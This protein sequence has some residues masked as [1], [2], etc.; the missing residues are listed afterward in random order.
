VES[1]SCRVGP[2]GVADVIKLASALERLAQKIARTSRDKRDRLAAYLEQIAGT[3]RAA[4]DDLV[5]GGDARDACS[6][7][8]KFVD[9]IPPTV[10]KALGAEETEELRQRLHEALGGRFVFAESRR[11]ADLQGLD[12]AAGTFTALA[13]YLRATD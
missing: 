4:R 8:H 6:Q 11:E 9:K 13:A 12:E 7:L 3:L 1:G 5:A 2:V 10:D